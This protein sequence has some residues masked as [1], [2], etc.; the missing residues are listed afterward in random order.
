MDYIV[1]VH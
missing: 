1:S